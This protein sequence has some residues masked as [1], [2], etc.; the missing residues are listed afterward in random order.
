MLSI[1]MIAR[2]QLLKASSLGSRMCRERNVVGFL[3]FRVLGFRV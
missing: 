1:A 2:I 3:G